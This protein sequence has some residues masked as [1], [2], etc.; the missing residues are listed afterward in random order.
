MNGGR[1]E[2]RRRD[3]VGRRLR[4]GRRVPDGIAVKSLAQASRTHGRVSPYRATHREG[5]GKPG[6]SNLRR[7]E[8]RE[9]L[10]PQPASAGKGLNTHTYGSATL[11]R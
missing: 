1:R 9:G 8:V 6:D 5:P 11:T 4:E 7:P 2:G 10:T 3:D